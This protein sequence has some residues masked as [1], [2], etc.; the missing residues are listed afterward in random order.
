MA[1]TGPNGELEIQPN[2]RSGQKFW[3]QLHE[4]DYLG[5][6][7]R[8]N[9]LHDPEVPVEKGFVWFT[10]E[11]TI[12]VPSTGQKGVK[13]TLLD[14]GIVPCW[15]D[16]KY[17]QVFAGGLPLGYFNESSSDDPRTLTANVEVDLGWAIRDCCYKGAEITLGPRPGQWVNELEG[18]SG[19]VVEKSGGLPLQV[20]DAKNTHGSYGSY[21]HQDDKPPPDIFRKL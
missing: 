21:L 13:I 11:E 2:V 15:L 12:T 8:P 9:K 16:L 1:P 20:G 5:P 4:F 18:D 7:N 10:V 17:L 3:A 14:E 19:C 6:K